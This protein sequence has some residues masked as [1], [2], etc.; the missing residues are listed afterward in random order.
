LLRWKHR[1]K[2][3]KFFVVVLKLHRPPL[4]HTDFSHSIFFTV[5]SPPPPRSVNFERALLTTRTMKLF[6][7]EAVLALSH[8]LSLSFIL[9]LWTNPFLVL[10]SSREQHTYNRD[11]LCTRENPK[12]S[13]LAAWSENCKWYSSLPLDAVVSSFCESF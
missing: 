7:A 5:R 1:L 9:V 12:V 6:S 10:D 3:M 2:V 8:S 4:K 11:S 13:G